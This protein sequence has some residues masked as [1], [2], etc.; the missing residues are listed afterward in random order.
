MSQT[1]TGKD[2]YEFGPFRVDPE[3][4]VLLRDGET[5]P[6]TPK[7]FQ[8]L[9]V[10]LRRNNQTVSKD[11]L[12]HSVWPDTFVEETNLTRNIFALRRA[13]GEDAQNRYI[14]T[15]SGQGYRLAG[16]VRLV[17]RQQL[18]VV[19]ATH[20]KVQVEVP[21]RRT[22]KW[23]I[24]GVVLAMA[25]AGVGIWR[26]FPHRPVLTEKDT[27]VL[28]DFTN[29]TGDPVFDE[30]LRQGL[31][32]QL[33]QSPYLSLVPD[34]RIRHTLGLM[35]I[36]AGTKLTPDL[37]RQVCTR[38]GSAAVLEGSIASLGSQYVLGLSAKNCRNGETLDAEM[39]QAARKEDVLNALTQIASRFRKRVGESPR[40]IESHDKPLAEATTPSLDALKAYSAAWEIHYRSGTIETIPLFRRAIDL[41]PGFAM[42]YASL[43]RMYDDLDQSDLAAKNTAKAWQLRD[44]TS[45]R[46]RFFIIVGYQSLVT[47]N[48]EV[49]RQTAESWAQMYPRD[50]LPRILLSSFL[51][52]VA[53]RFETAADEARKAIELD[54]DFSIG[55]LNLALNNAYMNRLDEAESALREADARGLAIDEFFMV[56]YSLAFLKGDNAAMQR[57]ADAARQRVGA[58]GWITDNEAFAAAYGGHLQHAR[59]LTRR[60][61][62]ESLHVSQQERAGL[63]L[64]GAAEREALFLNRSEA[65][66][67][68][69]AALEQSTG[70][71]VEYGAAFALALAGDA[72]RAQSLAVDLDKRHPED[73][74]VQFNY[75]PTLSAL[76]ALQRNDPSKA[77]QALQNCAPYDLSPP[78]Q[79]LG[80]LYPIYVRGLAYLAD[81]RGAEASQEFQKIVGHSGIVVSDPIGAMARL[82]L[83]RAFLLAGDEAKARSSYEEFLKLWKD[84]DPDVPI[85]VGARKEFAI[86]PR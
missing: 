84:A 61:V 59:G 12:M 55:Y 7:T 63:W 52:K 58:E 49:A 46:E 8:V 72:A 57:V 24:A 65:R 78:R 5:V 60:A 6:L 51:N 37:A 27:V 29:S 71:E 68:A 25:A 34:E 39:A 80:A 32:V 3:K 38:T 70:R 62:E 35:G 26:L 69:E 86:R 73:T 41:D 17:P 83:A 28:A 81:H 31:E 76:F 13:L 40:A 44:R 66:R 75:L 16:Q 47:G 85:L 20:F 36:S 79:L 2:L 50:A 56:R 67:Q 9:L 64:A 54:P 45:E 14:I 22:P 53:G 15:V 18:N 30:T 82:Q 42:A 77:I 43:G 21:A 48:Q 1:Q 23:I 10:L 74:L 33:E 4:Q 11:E 19:A